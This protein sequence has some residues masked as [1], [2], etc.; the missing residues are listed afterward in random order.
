MSDPPRAVDTPEGAEPLEPVEAA[1]DAEAEAH[2]VG[3]TDAPASAASGAS[4]RSTGRAAAGMGAMT[5]LS[6]V[7]GFVRVL[8]IITVLGTNDLGDAFQAA[9]LLSNV[10][11]ELLAA[12]ALSAVL[13]PTFVQLLDRG[14]Q[15]AA[16]EVAGRVLGVALLIL[17]AITVVGVA[18]SPLLADVLTAGA[19]PE[20]ADRQRDLVAF[21]LPFFL[22]QVLLYAAGT[23]A[24]A[25]LQARRH[26]AIT[27]AAPIGN[28]VVMVIGLALFRVAAGSEPGLDL[29]LGERLLLVLAGTGGVVGFVGMLLV[30]CA[31]SGFRLRPRRLRG[32]T[33][34]TA[35]LKHS[36]WGVALHTAGG[37]LLGAAILACSGVAGGVVAYNAAWVF[38]LAPYAVLAQ[39]VHTTILPELVGEA[40]DHGLRQVA[41][42]LRW[43]LERMGL[44]V[45]PV[46]AAMVALALPGMRVVVQFGE[47]G[48]AGV[49]LVAAALAGLAVGLYPYS[50]FL[51][52]S[53]GYYALDESRFPGLVAV[54]SAVVGVVG[55]GVAAVTLD[56][57]GRIAALGLAHSVAYTVGALVLAVDLRRRTG[58]S[59]LPAALGRMVLV[60]AAVGVAAWAGQAVL[61]DDPRRF[62]DIAYLAV[63]GALG[64]ALVVG[65]YQVLRVRSSLTNRGTA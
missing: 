24:S 44:L 58:G 32:D 59:L 40:R 34:V 28:T 7:A 21:L 6:R 61:G 43:A 27:A 48:R 42:S 5:A 12:G 9:N 41:A 20:V 64:G 13:V 22:P 57:A 35:V 1:A 33:R 29:T 3:D 19:D 4:A 62:A 56:G 16:E 63:A 39:P 65:A 51:L 53:R 11:F 38:F 46:T 30:A 17:G 23:V 31:R 37:L 26:F 54:G 47:T 25:V 60:S 50:A 18:A 55:M 8:V 36:G 14:D 2:A 10:L 52:F 45:L 15:D 49:G